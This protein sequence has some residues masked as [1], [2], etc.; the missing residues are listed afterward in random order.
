MLADRWAQVWYL[1]DPVLK[2]VEWALPRRRCGCCREVRAG[3]VPGVRNAAVGTVSYGP[4]LHAA[5]V[6]LASDAT[7]PASGPRWWS[8]R[9]SGCR[10]RPG[11]SPARTSGSPGTSRPPGSTRR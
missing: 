8:V 2:K 4:R 7:C 3:S 10:S 11:S 6:L 5:A 1:L 9:C